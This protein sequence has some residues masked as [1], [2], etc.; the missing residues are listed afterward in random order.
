MLLMIIM[1]TS[2]VRNT[3]LYHPFGKGVMSKYQNAL[4]NYGYYIYKLRLVQWFYS[5]FKKYNS[6]EST[7]MCEKFKRVCLRFLSCEFF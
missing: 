5:K 7:C 1:S 3:K 2:I 4:N 6:N